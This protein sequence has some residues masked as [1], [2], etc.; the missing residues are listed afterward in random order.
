M[1][2]SLRLSAELLA[3]EAQTSRPESRRNG[4]RSYR[5]CFVRAG[6]VRMA[7]GKPSDITIEARALESAVQAGLF[8]QR[9]VFVDHAPS[10]ELP[11]LRNLVG[12]TAGARYDPDDQAVYG[13]VH[14][15]A[16]KR[17]IAGLLD[18]VLAEGPAAPDI[19]LSIVF[20]PRWA[21]QG[22]HPLSG[23]R[24][25]GIQ[26]VESVDLVFEPAAG[27]RIL[28]ALS[29]LRNPNQHKEE[30]TM[31]ESFELEAETQPEQSSGTDWQQ[32]LERVQRR[33]GSRSLIRASDLPEASR[34][35]LAAQEFQSPA[36]VEQAIEAERHYLARLSEGN[37]VKLGGRAPRG[38]GIQV[39][40]DGAEQLQLA[41][42]ALL[43]GTQP[44]GNV[45][46]LTGIREAYIK[47]SGDYEMTGVFHSQRVG[48]STV[49]SSTMAGMVANALNKALVNEFQQYPRW[50]ERF[51]STQ[52]FSSLQ[53][54]KFITL[55]GI[56]EL[57]TV[58]EG[59][60][61]NELTWDDQTETAD[62]VKK[63]GYL[64]ITIEAIDKDD[65]RRLQ[66]APRA[67]AQAAWLTLGK[68]ISAI[69]TSN[70]GTGPNLSDSNPLFDAAN[71]GNLGS[72]ALNVSAWTATRAAMRKQTDV[73]SGERL[74]SLT[75]PKYLLV[76]PDLEITALQ[77][78][79]SE[80]DYSYAVSNAPAAPQ[81]VFAEGNSLEARM[82]AARS[83]VVVV[84][85]WTDTNDWAAVADPRLY[86]SIGI[87][88]R[89]GRVPEVFSVASPSTGLMFSN[90]TM[91][92]KVRFFFAVGPTDW[93]GLYKHNVS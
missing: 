12:V 64:G 24:I 57:P 42:E 15:Y 52:D 75:A 93:R 65:T 29:S 80:H 17:E 46:P 1:T 91:P 51:T 28:Q 79:A 10:L 81:N 71:H 32:A 84:D 72:S 67:L 23:R 25:I 47:L 5:C 27:G 41:M 82:N 66:A 60:S 35:R 2:L 58:A 89:Y 13:E 61:Y 6:S 68:A 63:G 20:W 8:D 39:G 55:G 40:L 14:L 18:E 48:L 21:P 54:A 49:N 69:F 22:F 90:D 87:G 45:A 50:W 34:E 74:G 56:G 9:A 3:P 26:H 44:P 73:H 88:F 92:V 78:L 37:V 38:G 33:E 31:T 4:R 19:G 83:R 86:P 59:A 62:F 43:Q 85:L 30:G 16:H 77:V 76:P 36:E 7:G 53:Q 11:S 70:S